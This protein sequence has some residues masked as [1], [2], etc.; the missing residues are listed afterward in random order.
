MNTKGHIRYRTKDNKIVVGCTTVVGQIAKPALIVWANRLGLDGIDSAKYVDD[1]AEIGTL[2]HSIITDGLQGRETDFSGY[3]QNQRDA[4]VWCVRSWDIWSQGREIE[5]ILMEAPLVSERYRYG[6]TLDIYAT[7]DGIKTLI[8]LK[9][10]NDLWPEHFTQVS[11]YRQLLIENGHEVDAVRILNIPRSKT[12]V[13]KEAV[14]SPEVLDMNF[15][16]FKHLLRIYEI[17][18]ELKYV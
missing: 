2:A 3:D 16:I 1:T 11:A 7:I 10:T 15:E 5:P 18:K 17:R 9:S 6:G 12:A 8:D 13:F 14:L 4:A